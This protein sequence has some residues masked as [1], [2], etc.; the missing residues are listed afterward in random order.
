MANDY[1]VVV[2]AGAVGKP[3]IVHDTVTGQAVAAGVKLDLASG[4][5]C[6]ENGIHIARPYLSRCICVCVETVYMSAS[7]CVE[8]DRQQNPI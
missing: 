7:V 5:I 8:R 3:A 4:R 6:I 1:L 2:A